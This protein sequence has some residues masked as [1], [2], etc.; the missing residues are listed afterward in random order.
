MNT[1]EA[2]AHRVRAERKQRGYTQEKLAEILG[3][4]PKTVR[5]WETM[6]AFPENDALEK[7]AQEFGG[8]WFRDQG[9]LKGEEPR[10]T[11][12]P[13]TRTALLIVVQAVEETEQL[14]SRVT[15]LEAEVEKLRSQVAPPATN[16]SP[17]KETLD[18]ALARYGLKLT[19]F[20]E[21]YRKRPGAI[22]TVL[23]AAD[24]G[25]PNAADGLLTMAMQEAPMPGEIGE[26]MRDEFERR[27]DKGDE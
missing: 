17:R 1:R 5:N 15:E 14:R 4:H 2:V 24:R 8:S 6:K 25:E 22:W 11:E 27:D 20:Q 9:S 18:H 16:G 21:L 3:V 7:M 10:G 26:A 12:P 19:D 23:N 13:D